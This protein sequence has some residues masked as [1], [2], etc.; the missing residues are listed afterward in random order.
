MHPYMSAVIKLDREEIGIIGRVHPSLK[1]DDIFVF[2]ISL[3]KLM[4]TIKPIKYKAASIYPMIIKDL[5]FVTDKNTTSL[6]IETIIKKSGGRL[7][8]DIS[9]FDVY[10]GEKLNDNEKSIAYSLTFNDPTRTLTEEEVMTVFNK[11][12]IDVEKSGKGKLRDN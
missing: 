9:V 7:L 5:A 8:T 4:K 1:K 10:T 3:N 6:E 11:I 12:I 2:E